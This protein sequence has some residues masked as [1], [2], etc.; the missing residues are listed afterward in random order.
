MLDGYK[1]DSEVLEAEMMDIE[2]NRRKYKLTT[3]KL[4]AEINE[5]RRLLEGLDGGKTLR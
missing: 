1:R 5:Y 3:E 4:Q 2:Q